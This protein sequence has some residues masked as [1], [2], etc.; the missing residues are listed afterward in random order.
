MHI[1][2]RFA[3]F[4]NIIYFI[5]LLYDSFIFVLFKKLWDDLKLGYTE[6]TGNPLLREEIAKLHGVD[7]DDV[8]VVVPQEGI[9]IEMKCLMNV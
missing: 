5:T 7:K 9:Y 6:M 2:G 3:P 1:S 8:L 4:C